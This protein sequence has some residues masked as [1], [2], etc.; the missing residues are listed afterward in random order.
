MDP[1]IGVVL[2]KENTY[3]LKNISSQMDNPAVPNNH[4]YKD[5]LKIKKYVKQYED[6]KK[7]KTRDNIQKR[8]PYFTVEAPAS[9]KKIRRNVAS[10]LCKHNIGLFNA[11]KEYDDRI[12]FLHFPSIKKRTMF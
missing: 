2:R 9:T 6:E 5:Y 10:L 4:A 12:K 3:S 11:Y 8:F 1:L 7:R